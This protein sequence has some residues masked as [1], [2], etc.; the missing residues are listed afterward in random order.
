MSQ[1]TDA[2]I[3]EARR[4][5]GVVESP[6]NSNRGLCIDYWIREAGLDPAG[7]F[8]WCMAFV[9]QMGRQAVGHRWPCPR[10]AGV[11]VLAAWAASKPGVLQDRPAVGDLF[12]L[13][14]ESLRRF[15]HVGIV[16]RVTGDSYETIEG[17][18]NG[19]GG[20]EGFGVFARVRR[21]EGKSKFVRWEAAQ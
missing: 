4:Y 2:L 15:A 20:R 5:L 10:T 7:A 6:K 18:T 17:N 16:T 14:N 12:I 19:G 1:Q 13:W 8:P 11:A 9:G 3:A 21:V